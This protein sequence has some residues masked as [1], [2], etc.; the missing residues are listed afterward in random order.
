MFFVGF[1]SFDERYSSANIRTQNARAVLLGAYANLSKVQ[2]G[3][4]LPV[5]PPS[6]PWLGT[7]GGMEMWIQNKG[8]GGSAQ[9]A[10]IVREFIAKAKQ[11]PE[12]SGVTSTF[13][14]A[15]QQLQVDVDRTKSETLGVPVQDVYSVMQTMFGSLYVRS[16]TRIAACGK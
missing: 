12:L 7:T 9:L 6:I 15:S 11:R 1:K 4:V 16:S 3:I 10:A 2:E 14:A 8:D 13:N 5:N